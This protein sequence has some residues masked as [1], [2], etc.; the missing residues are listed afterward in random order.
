MMQTTN[1]STF[2]VLETMQYVQRQYR[3]VLLPNSSYVVSAQYGG[4][5]LQPSFEA[6]AAPMSSP[7]YH[8]YPQYPTYVPPTHYKLHAQPYYRYPQYAIYVPP[9]HYSSPAPPHQPVMV[10]T[11]QCHANIPPRQRRVQP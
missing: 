2:L 10:P 7:S 3:L 4:N 1:Y 8:R 9:T 5:I 11:R 6:S